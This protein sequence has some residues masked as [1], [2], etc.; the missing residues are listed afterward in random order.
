M[1]SAHSLRLS[2]AQAVLLFSNLSDRLWVHCA[3]WWLQLSLC[4]WLWIC[5]SII[6]SLLL[7][8]C[9]LLPSCLLL[10]SCP[11]T[12]GITQ[13]CFSSSSS[14]P[15]WRR[16]SCLLTQASHTCTLRQPSGIQPQ[17]ICTTAILSHHCCI[18]PTSCPPLWCGTSHPLT[19]SIRKGRVLWSISF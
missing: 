3:G 4:I 5:P 6:T 12:Y 18:Q 17:A 15:L 9:I 8:S 11:A 10:T 13:A 7:S 16:P 1:F 14:Y 2:F 19:F